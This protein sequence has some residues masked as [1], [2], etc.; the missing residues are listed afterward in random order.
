MPRIKIVAPIKEFIEAKT[1]IESGADEFFFGIMTKEYIDFYSDIVPINKRGI[2]S[3]FTSFQD[4]EQLIKICSSKR[5]KLSLTLNSPFY[6]K[7][8][9][10]F[11]EE[12]LLFAKQNG[13]SVIVSDL[14]LFER[15]KELG[16][17]THA[18]AISSILNSEAI[19]FFKGFGASRIILSRDFSLNE[20]KEISKKNKGIE[21]EAFVLN[22]GCKN[23]D[24]HCTFEHGTCEWKEEKFGCRLRYNYESN[25]KGIIGNRI[26]KKLK[27]LEL[28]SMR[29][30][31]CSVKGLAESG[32]THLKIS[33]RGSELY[34]KIN[35]I[36][37]LKTLI[38]NSNLSELEF[39][40]Y[41]KESYRQIYGCDCNEEC[42]Y[43]Q[44]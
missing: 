12:Q 20:L 4:A 23:I 43:G 42:Y 18:S 37:Y 25:V 30:A 39:R 2:K 24:G 3:N 11:I 19:S 15:C 6:I 36:K 35:D 10:K 28:K 14:W 41:A 38:A 9:V 29:C 1:L 33:G 5:I 32:I 8:Q 40:I 31:G 27:S 13:V 22:D 26:N 17:E 21:L 44:N 7:E 34:N 16:I